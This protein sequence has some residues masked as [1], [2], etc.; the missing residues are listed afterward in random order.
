MNEQSQTR[1]ANPA[2]DFNRIELMPAS[3]TMRVGNRRLTMSW[4]PRKPVPQL[5]TGLL[6]RS[7][8]AMFGSALRMS[9]TAAAICA[10]WNVPAMAAAPGVNTL[11]TGGVITAGTATIAQN[12]NTLNINQSS[13]AA[14]GNFTSFS[15]GANAVVDISQTSASNAFLARVTGADPSQIYGLLKSNGTVVLVNQNGLMVGPGGVVDVARF[16]GSTLNIS[17]SD[18]LAGR[19]T[20]VNGGNAGNI[21]NQGTIKSATGGSV[22]LIGASVTNNGIIHSPNGEVLLAAGQTVQLIDTATPGVTVCVTGAA[23]SVTNLG[24]IT[25]EAGRIGI[26]AGLVTNSGNI[27]ASSV[28]SEGGR[29]FLRAS[30]KLTTTANSKITADGVTKG[31]SVVLYSDG[32]AYIDGD[33]SARGAPGLGGFVETSGKKTLDVVKAPDVGTGGEWLIDPYDLTVVA[34]GTS[35]V[36]NSGS[37]ITSTGGSATIEAG[38]IVTQLNLGNSVTLTT[39]A[40][41]AANGGN[42]TVNAAINKTTGTDAALT[43]NADN[44][45]IIN[46]DITSTSN[47]LG[48]NLNTNVN[49]LTSGTHS[50]QVNSATIGLNGGVLTVSEGSGGNGNGNLS[51]NNGSFLNLSSNLIAVG[52]PVGGNVATGNLTINTGGSLSNIFGSNVVVTGTLLNNGVLNLQNSQISTGSMTNSA[53]MTLANVSGTLGTVVNSGTLGLSNLFSP[54]TATSVSNSGTLTLTSSSTLTTT[55]TFTNAAGGSVTL[56]SSTLNANTNLFNAGAIAVNNGATLQAGALNNTGGT[57]VNA[58]TLN[59]ASLTNAVGA[60]V[61][62]SDSILSASDIVHNAGTFITTNSTISTVNG[63]TNMVSGV[64]TMNYLSKINGSFNNQGLVSAY[65][66]AGFVTFENGFT[67]S[68]LMNL[69]GS[70]MANSSATNS[71]GGTLNLG[72]AGETTTLSGSGLWGND[73]TLNIVGAGNEVNLGG[74]LMNNQTGTML[75][76]GTGTSLNMGQFSNSGIV[77]IGSGGSATVGGSVSNSG[78][79]TLS[80][81][82]FASNGFSNEES[83]TV[84]GTGSITVGGGTG[85]FTNNGILS[86]GGDNAVGSLSILGNFVQGGKGILKLDFASATNYDKITVLGSSLGL[87]GTLITKLLDTYR[88]AVGTTFTPIEGAISSTGSF[89]YVEGDIVTSGGVKNM[90][91]AGYNLSGGQSGSDALR[92]TMSA[93]E[94]ITYTGSVESQWSDINSWSSHYIPTAIDTVVIPTDR[95]AV[96]LGS[97]PETL[98][99]ITV[100]SGG[101]FA[102]TGGNLTVNTIRSQGNFSINSGALT[103]LGTGRLYS[104]SLGGT[105]NGGINS[106]LNVTDNFVQTS[107]T[108]NSAGDVALSQADGDLF[109]GSITARNLVLEAQT[110]SIGQEDTSLHVTKQLLTSSATGTMLTGSNRIAAYAG[111]N[112]VSGD[113]ILV[114]NLEVA[115]TSVVQINGVTNANGNI[116]ISNTGGAA[117]TAIGSN[118][119]FLGSMPTES[120]T[121]ISAAAHLATLGIVTN[122]TMSVAG[123]NVDNVGYSVALETHSPL[124]IGVGGISATGNINLTA[125]DSGSPNDNLI[126]NGVISSAGGNI[127]LVAGNNMSINANIS[128]SAPGTAL[129]TVTNGVLTYAPGVSVTDAS[130]TVVPVAVVVTQ[131]VNAT[132][133]EDLKKLVDT[134]VKIGTTDVINNLQKPPSQTLNLPPTMFTPAKA[135]ISTPANTQTTGGTQGSFGGD[136]SG[137]GTPV[138]G[139]TANTA[140]KPL[141]VCT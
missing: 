116:N 127:A 110:G 76:S 21:D 82:S 64:L 55:G 115:D 140:K 86:P 133:P 104:L 75:L 7:W 43:L 138:G 120:G 56:N 124:T 118:A 34:T 40:G 80:G 53:S 52:L 71:Q 65:G 96:Y 18:F 112:R 77:T 136:D 88:P 108:I 27:N 1:Q 42:I 113:I 125:G 111:N 3:F 121:P 109:V 90:I 91:K 35:A 84:S 102:M 131:I 62:L 11:P 105:L 46:A 28:V 97:R 130:G 48:L 50:A 129:F 54:V 66:S 114:N 23:G 119:D 117:T 19:L 141:P 135:S 14:I 83:G 100:N 139:D 73:G 95:Y 5:L 29:I 17:D 2:Q 132:P 89:R 98:E 74:T 39:G 67:N 30:Q 24:T 61:T 12:G 37:V 45:I 85:V 134:P 69:K 49:G 70:I 31:G 59:V 99:K 101:N 137:S 4:R 20:F 78:S 63:L 8:R 123:S 44:N 68:G 33:V 72:A 47:K 6:R 9:V 103:L 26:A 60:S 58:S 92:L 106:I 10:A 93:P 13:S 107:G 87:G 128:T 16:I 38:T 51:I 94:E 25:A 22:Y 79:L 57:T 32:A 36:S 81:A 41:G 126:V 15:I 122:G